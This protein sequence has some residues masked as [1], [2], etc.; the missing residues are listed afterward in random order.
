MPE[1]DK[2]EIDET[3]ANPDM[4]AELVPFSPHEEIASCFYALS[5]VEDIDAAILSDRDKDRIRQ[6]KRYSLRIIHYHIKDL[7]TDLFEIKDQPKE[8]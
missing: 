1:D 5:A 3:S 2:I 6:I 4:E 7:Y 8:D